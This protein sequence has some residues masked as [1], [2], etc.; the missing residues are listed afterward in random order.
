M[1][2]VMVVG[3]GG[4]EHALAWRLQVGNG[5]TKRDDRRVLLCPGNAGAARELECVA[6]VGEGVAGYVA[7]A[8]AVGA[9]L[10]VVGPEQP[11]VDGLADALRTEGIA[12]LGPGAEA[13]QL[14][15]S[16][17]YTKRVLDEAGAPT[18]RWAVLEDVAQVDEVL[19]GFDERVVVKADGLAAGKGV[20]VCDTRAEARDAARAMLGADGDPRF[21]SASTTVLIEERLSGVELS[22]IALC[23]GERAVP[24]ACARDHKRLRD[25]DEGPNTGGMGAVAPLGADEGVSEALLAEVDERVFRPV[26]RVMK[27]RGAPFTGFLYAGIMLDESKDRGGMQVLE[28]NVRFGDPEAQAVLFG[29]GVD[30]LPVFMGVA[31]GEPMPAELDLRRDCR[32]TAT[33]VLASRG[34]PEA[35]EKGFPITGL[36]TDLEGGQSAKVFFA[37][38]KAS[39]DGGLLTAGGRVLACTAT[40]SSPADAIARAYAAAES[41]TFEGRHLRRDIGASLV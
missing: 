37:G 18:G 24:F 34:Y 12:V 41:V 27:A 1:T 20:V 40:G 32:P 4:R 14:E 22:V 30:L 26:L 33:I 5:E 13:A 31:R 39:D 25:G 2:T 15:A 28:F 29:T 23:D 7:T 11:L 16:K 9:D 35:P 36:D 6:N 21:G 19:A 38:V 3:S 17:I 8:K 10:V